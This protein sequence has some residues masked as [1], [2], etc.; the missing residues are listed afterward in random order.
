MLKRRT[1]L[2]QLIYFAS[3]IIL[4]HVG[5]M[6]IGTGDMIIAGRY[7]R[8]SLAAVGSP[9]PWQIPL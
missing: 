6:L 5:I 8:E 9:S 7:S 2:R 4:G 1:A 3:P